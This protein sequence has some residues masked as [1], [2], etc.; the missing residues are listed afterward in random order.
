MNRYA[1][2]LRT[3]VMQIF[4]EKIVADAEE[5]GVRNSAAYVS[6]AAASHTLEE[7]TY[8]F[9]L[10]RFGLRAAAEHHLRS[11]VEAVERDYSKVGGLH[12][13]CIQSTHNA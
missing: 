8:D 11:L 13:W 9:F 12:S 2:V 1:E 7:F 5:A 4:C 3:V 10:S 6:D